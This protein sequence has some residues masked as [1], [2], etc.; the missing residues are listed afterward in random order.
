[1]VG[2]SV[3]V[4]VYN[5][6]DSLEELVSRLE[7]VLRG[8]IKDSFEILMVDD[9]SPNPD[10]W[11]CLEQLAGEHPSLQAIQLTRN[12]GRHAAVQCGL[13][14]ASG[15][16]MIVMDDDLQHRPEDLPAM[17]ARKGHDLVFAAYPRRKPLFLRWMISRIRN[18]LDN[19]TINKPKDVKLG[20]FFLANG[21][22]IR[23]ALAIKTLDPYL[24]AL[25]FHIAQDAVNVEVP[26][27]PRKR[28]RS[29]YSFSKLGAFIRN[30][31]TNNSSFPLRM[32]SWLGT[33]VA[34]VG[35]GSGV[36]LLFWVPPDANPASVAGWVLL[37]VSLMVGLVFLA[38]AIV[39]EYL[40]R[41]I[42]TVEGRAPYVV[43]RRL[44]RGEAGLGEEEES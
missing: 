16:Y 11:L 19:K 33:L 42:F 24:P 36:T 13:A 35:A 29:G 14:H 44:G 6:T 10:T 28:G 15:R 2:Y 1:M 7:A 22:I 18:W 40:I 21:E 43:R 27:E 37:N 12:F 23:A 41:I 39:G 30:L 32:I 26:H 8:E 38:F 20:P 5:S 31:L 34:A 3:V 4:P 25:L 17:I 9:G